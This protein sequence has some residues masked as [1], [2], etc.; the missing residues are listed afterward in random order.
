MVAAEAHKV[1]GEPAT[2]MLYQASAFTSSFIHTCGQPLLHE[3]LLL[4][5]SPSFRASGLGLRRS[6]SGGAAFLVGRAS[7][8]D[9]KRRSP[10]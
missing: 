2:L 7:G 3:A 8:K 10:C 4:I 9:A 1:G 6:S 5:W